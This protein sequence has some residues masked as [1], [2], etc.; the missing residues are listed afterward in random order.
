[1]SEAA[2]LRAIEE[3]RKGN[4]AII[5]D[6]ES[7]EN[8]GDLC[9]AAEKVTP[10][11]INFLARHASGLICVALEAQRLDDLGIEPM[12]N[13]P[14]DKHKSAFSVSVDAKGKVTTGISAF[15][16]A[17]TI[18]HLLDP[19]A[20]P[21]DFAKPGHVLPLRAQKGGVLVR[22]GHT[23]AS[24]DLARLA[25]LYPAAVICEVMAEDGTMARLPQLEE[26][27]KQHGFPIVT[28]RDLIEYR[29]RREKLVRRV[30]EAM[31]PTKFGEFTSIAYESLVD[32]QAYLALVKG[33]V[34]GRENVLV[35]MHS[36]C[37]TGDALHSLRCDCGA[38]LEAA[39]KMIQR[40]GLGV[41][42]YIYHQEGRGI[43]LLNKHLAYQLQD[44][45]K[46]TVEA[47]EALGFPAD[48]R[49]YGIGAQVLVD[50][51]LSSLRLLTNNPK[52][53]VGLEGYGLTA[54]MVPLEIPPNR[55]NRRYLATKRA[56]L[57]H[58]L[59]LVDTP[60]DAKDDE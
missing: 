23:E 30:S 53:V 46:D 59:T 12:V 56:K 25:G 51:G 43:G 35:R 11:H 34:A 33:S 4:F 6:D 29:S 50:L 16:R 54:T 13:D 1:M 24:T 27:A 21:S 42:I 3:F 20:K 19:N 18:R 2:V 40:E 32:R 38:Q 45:G 44:K 26:I 10:Q 39:L 37:L 48:L 31:L 55:F 5:V 28:V 14:T 57:G 8:E 49:D 41:L 36:G 22:A 47:N 17:A 9:V 15:D 58:H 60:T 7:R 52:K